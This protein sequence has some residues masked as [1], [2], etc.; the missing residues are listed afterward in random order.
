MPLESIDQFLSETFE[1][2]GEGGKIDAKEFEKN[3]K[4]EIDAKN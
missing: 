1:A 3:L 4:A 2:A